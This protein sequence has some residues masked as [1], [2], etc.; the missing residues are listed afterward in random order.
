MLELTMH[1]DL[2]KDG[3]ARKGKSKSN[4]GWTKEEKAMM[5]KLKK[6]NITLKEAFAHSKTNI[7]AVIETTVDKPNW[8]LG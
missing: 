6:H 4:G 3:V 2:L 8:P 1:D 7:D 5:K